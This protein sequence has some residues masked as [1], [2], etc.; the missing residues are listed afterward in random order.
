MGGGCSRSARCASAAAFGVVGRLGQGARARGGR[1]RQLRFSPRRPAAGAPADEPAADGA[2][3]LRR[4]RRLRGRAVDARVAQDD[5]RRGD[6]AV[7]RRGARRAAAALDD[8]EAFWIEFPSATAFRAELLR[9][10]RLEARITEAAKAGG[11]LACALTTAD[12]EQQ[13]APLRK[14]KRRKRGRGS[15]RGRR[16]DRAAAARGRAA[17]TAGPAQAERGG[18]RAEAP[19]RAPPG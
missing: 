5:R 19:L 2:P 16:A 15:G 3:A 7:P 14:R 17:A 10:G 6:R 8:G 12:P 1:G 13:R 4:A 9:L 11:C 18:A